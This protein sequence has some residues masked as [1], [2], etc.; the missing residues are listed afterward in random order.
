MRK[1]K[2]CGKSRCRLSARQCFN[3]EIYCDSC[4]NSL[5]KYPYE[6]VPP[7]GELHY[8][9]SGKV[10]CHICGRGFDVLT[11]HIQTVHKIT[12]SE[13][14]K[15]FGLNRGARLTSKRIQESYKDNPVVNIANIR[16][17]FKKGHKV[18]EG[19]ER[20]LQAIKERVGTKYAKQRRKG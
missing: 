1:C 17:P 18:C 20:R 6:Y 11:S 5:K 16:V 12:A 7:M 9:S 4:Y 13:Y 19:K 15:K 3:D 10:L 8:G 2:L 14:K